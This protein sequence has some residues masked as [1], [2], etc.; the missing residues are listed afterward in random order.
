M[1]L[2]IFKAGIALFP[3]EISERKKEEVVLS[4]K[5]LLIKIKLSMKVFSSQPQTLLFLL[6]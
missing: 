1:F 6:I 5:C 2:I 3:G 4:L